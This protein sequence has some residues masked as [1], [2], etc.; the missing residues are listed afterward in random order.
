[1]KEN[2]KTIFYIEDN[3]SSRTLVK[4]VM[5]PLGYKMVLASDAEDGIERMK[6]DKPDL[7]LM[8][9]NMPGMNGYELTT[10]LKNTPDLIS[11]P[12][13]ALTSHSIE[14]EKEMAIMAG[15]DG[16]ISKPID[17]EL[18]PSLIDEYLS[19]RRD[20]IDPHKK[21]YYLKEYSRR[22][23]ARLEE[24][25]GEL[26]KAEKEWEDTFDAIADMVSI[27]DREGRILKANLSFYKRLGISP[28]N[29]VGQMCHEILYGF[30]NPSEDYACDRTIKTCKPVEV[31]VHNPHLR[32]AFFVRTYPIFDK[33]GVF[34][35]FVHVV[36]DITD[37][38]QMEEQI[39]QMDKLS[40]IGELVSG[41]A[42]ELNNPLTGI[43]GYTE[44]LID[45]GVDRE[46]EKG[47][48]IIYKEAERA[49]N[50]IR[51]MLDFSR[52]YKPEMREVDVNHVVET[53][54][55][56]KGYQ[57]KSENIEVIKELKEH[58]QFIRADFN[59]L[60][61]VLLNI[62]NNA[63]Y[64]MVHNNEKGTLI[65]KTFVDD[66]S[67]SISVKDNG[68]GIEKDN[69]GKIFEPFFTTKEAGKGTG[70]GL[71]ICKKIISEHGGTIEL[72][73]EVGKGSVFT[74]KLPR[75]K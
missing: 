74:I 49:A 70:L 46:V 13:I 1:M 50:I 61:Q 29:A 19:G 40:E 39:L 72:E 67:V 14:G 8:D 17:V 32:G 4:R 60:Q 16:F 43:M 5:E 2:M 24:K 26:L 68:P 37:R 53:I 22:L 47:L 35:S 57:M 55:V 52:K 15:C 44:H 30:A 48:K 10:K 54:L 20:K 34:T 51:A 75:Y 3:E 11:I 9:V 56:L 69:M 42:H 58:I 59:Q 7:I 63:H 12:V 6:S 66:T 25:I 38:K 73:S 62:I 64:A 65:I 71:S 28:G 18:F 31:E 23:V 33:K 21:S 27:H 41:V 45:T 36:A